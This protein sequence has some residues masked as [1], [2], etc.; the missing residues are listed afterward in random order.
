M[1]LRVDPWETDYGASVDLDD[2]LE[3]AAGLGLSPDA[4][5]TWRPLPAPARHPLPCCAFV[6]GVRR[7]DVRL[8]AENGGATLPALAG[9]WAAGCAW[10]TR[11][12]AFG[13]LTLGR[14]LV[15]GGGLTPGAL[16][17]RI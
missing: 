13:A 16:E 10:S 2:G 11:P 9:S 17:T 3:P 4:P 7:I 1:Q 6:D 5:G 15:V 14:E 12:P 8:F